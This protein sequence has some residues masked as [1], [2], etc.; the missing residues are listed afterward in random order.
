[1]EPGLSLA[2][3]A[4]GGQCCHINHRAGV[5]LSLDLPP[6]LGYLLRFT[7]QAMCRV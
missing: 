5:Q 1:V 6:R 4:S 3:L 7:P 2:A